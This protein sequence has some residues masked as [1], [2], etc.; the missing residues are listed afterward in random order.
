MGRTNAGEVQLKVSVGDRDLDET[1][2][3]S[4]SAL[5]VGFAEV[6]AK[7]LEKLLSPERTNGAESQPD[8]QSNS[9]VH[10]GTDEIPSNNE[11]M[12]RQTVSE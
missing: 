8:T 3:V 5:V 1:Y 6:G 4:A 9:V 12:L 2:S 7:V 11:D 10:H